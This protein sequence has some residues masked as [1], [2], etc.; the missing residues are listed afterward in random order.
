MFRNGTIIEKAAKMLSWINLARRPD[1]YEIFKICKNSKDFKYTICL[2][3]RLL[4]LY[5]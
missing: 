4:Q 3:N 5:F 1:V 2:V